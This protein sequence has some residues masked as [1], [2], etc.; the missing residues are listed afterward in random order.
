MN[1]TKSF[2]ALAAFAL[3]GLTIQAS[4]VT[5]DLGVSAQDFI[6]NGQGAVVNGSG[7]FGTY[8]LQQGDCIASGGTTTCTLSGAIV[9]GRFTWIYEWNLFFYYDIRYQ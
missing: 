4:T 9:S 7:T 6:E 5:V 3:T 8:T 2:F 1:N